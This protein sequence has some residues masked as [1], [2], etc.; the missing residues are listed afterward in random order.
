MKPIVSHPQVEFS[1]GFTMVYTMVYHIQSWILP[2][3]SPTISSIGNFW[4]KTRLAELPW[5]D[6]RHVDM[7][8]S[9]VLRVAPS[10]S[11]AILGSPIRDQVWGD[12][13]KDQSAPVMLVL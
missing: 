8:A 12:G 3:E 4:I 6:T 7:L 11:L 13:I 5:N 9:C 2:E 10:R 1:I